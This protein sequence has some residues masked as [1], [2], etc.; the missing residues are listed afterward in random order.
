MDGWETRRRRQ[1]GHDHAIIKLAFPGRIDSINID[2]SHF[3]G[4]FPPA[5]AIEAIYSDSEPNDSAEWQPLVATRELQGNSHN[6]VDVKSSAVVNY[7]RIHLYPDGGVARLRVYGTVYKNWQEADASQTYELSSLAN[8]GLIVGYND[9]HYGNVSSLLSAGRGVT[10]GD[11]W[12]TRRRREPGFDWIIIALGTAGI[13]RSI[14]VDTAYFKG[15]FPDRCSVQ[16]ALLATDMPKEAIITQSQFWP[17]LM[18]Q[19]TLSAD[20]IHTFETEAILLHTPVTHL[21][22]NI[23][24]DGGI[25]RFRL[26]GT[27]S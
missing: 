6:L 15:N 18:A 24:P 16:A 27:A 22:L 9:A 10:M 23:Y 11:G 13:A 2:T 26:F 21:R 4:N 14:E 19:K 20:A 3:T 7:L 12:E 8:G 17:D 25:S 5:A 1:G